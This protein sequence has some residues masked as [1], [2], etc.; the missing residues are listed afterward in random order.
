MH[1]ERNEDYPI[2][3]TVSTL[4]VDHNIIQMLN[5]VTKSF[6][7]YQYRFLGRKT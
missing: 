1:E 7:T 4:T 2:S 6:L 5:I 3:L